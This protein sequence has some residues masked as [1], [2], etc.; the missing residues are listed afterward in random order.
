MRTRNNGSR[1]FMTEL[2]FSILFFIIVSAICIQCFATAYAK[3]RDAS[4]ITGAVNAATNAAERYLVEPDFE[5]F[6]EYYDEN[7]QI[8]SNE[9]AY[10]TTAIITDAEDKKSCQSL[11]IVVATNDDREIYSLVVEKALK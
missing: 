1:I 9:G 2:M 5:G 8:V 6:T 4:E 3:S 11:H 10:K 7:W